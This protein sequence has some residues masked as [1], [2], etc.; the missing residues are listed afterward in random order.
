MNPR[1][2]H[3]PLPNTLLWQA[4]DLLP[5]GVLLVEVCPKPF[6]AAV[7]Y[8]NPAL[9]LLSG[10]E[11]E[12][13]LDQRPQCLDEQ[14]LPPVLHLTLVEHLANGAPLEYHMHLPSKGGP[15]YWAQVVWQPLSEDWFMITHRDI[16]MTV[17]LQHQ[18]E[19]GQH[20]LKQLLEHSDAVLRVMDPSGQTVYVSP[21]IEKVLGFTQDEFARLR[22]QD[23]IH[24]EDLRDML[25]VHREAI[26]TPGVTSY[27][28]FEYRAR[29]KS[30]GERWLSTVSRKVHGPTGEQF[31]LSTRDITLRKTTELKLQ[32]QLE[33]YKNLLDL[34]E[35]IE[36]VSDPDTLAEEALRFLLPLTEYTVGAFI[37][38]HDVQDE[39]RLCIGED[40]GQALPLLEQDVIGMNR[41]KVL[42]AVPS[43]E[44]VFFS[45]TEE[46]FIEGRFAT[47]SP[48]LAFLP[49][50]SEQGL[51]GVLLLGTPREVEVT[52][53]TRRLCRAV[54]ERINLA[55]NRLLDVEKL[56]AA[57]EETLRAMGLVLEYRDFETKGHT[58]RVVGLASQLGAQLGLDAGQLEN[59]RLGAYLHDVGKVAVPD[60]VLL[61]PGKLSEE[62]WTFI[63][64]HP[65]VGFELLQHIPTVSSEA[66]EVVLHHQ[67]RWNGSGYP[68]G[69]QGEDI[70][71]LARVFA[72]VDVYD[73]LTSE[74]PYK[75]AWTHEEALVQL[76]REAGT[77]LDL[78]VVQAFCALMDP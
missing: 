31:H 22:F 30:G 56:E 29:H 52:S 2:L 44:P 23:Y 19:L 72:V 69:L 16:T 9:T 35:R 47:F 33:R 71:V 36:S 58:D 48:T 38:L 11:P 32:R 70:P 62:E 61:K 77:L 12:D 59:L 55:Y 3:P 39:L 46:H 34:T 51:Q 67:E 28:P 25:G 65:G 14:R 20:H 37:K 74:R 17:S 6:S 43:N 54:M 76:N 42:Q 64:K 21:S 75:R 49:L 40:A 26:R 1:N 63:K 68:L 73:A 10:F 60:Q 53:A 5:D 15:G 7:R 8:V 41:S 57:R 45:R 50:A 4:L 18:N 66:L 13:L 78:G 24:A 27:G